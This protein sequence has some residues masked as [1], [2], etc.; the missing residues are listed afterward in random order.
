MFAE[1]LKELRKKQG[2]TQQELADKL[3]LSRSAIAKYEIGEREPNF[4][5]AE[6]IAD[7]FNCNLDSLISQ[8][9][10]TDYFVTLKRTELKKAIFGT[11]HISDEKLDEVLEYAKF[12]K[13]RGDGEW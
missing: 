9:Q 10:I 4:E 12:V 3:G 5:T 6:L 11:A 1:K 2:L 13:Q 8:K 7:F